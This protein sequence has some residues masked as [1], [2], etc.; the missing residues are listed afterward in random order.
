MTYDQDNK[1]IGKSKVASSVGDGSSGYE[2]Y[3]K[4]ISDSIYRLIR[5][6]ETTLRD[7]Q[8][9]IEYK[10]DSVVTQFSVDKNLNFEKLDEEK[11]QW[12]KIITNEE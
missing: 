1:L 6:E 5:L 8:D 11:F 9:T 3:G 7:D 2:E 12:N 10:I 4:F